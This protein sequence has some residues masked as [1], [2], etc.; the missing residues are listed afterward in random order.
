MFLICNG[1]AYGA[2]R[3]HHLSD[4]LPELMQ[5][6]EQQT[7]M[8]ARK[9]APKVFVSESIPTE[10]R[11]LKCG[12]LCNTYA[13]NMYLSRDNVIWLRENSRID[14]LVHELVHF[15]QSS[16]TDDLWTGSSDELETE[17]IR[18]QDTYYRNGDDTF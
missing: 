17:A 7:G 16:D 2:T 18:I 15:Y 9:T 14:Q 12:P 6:I 5:D 11:V 1:L 10:L 3:E 13:P 8:H 4:Y